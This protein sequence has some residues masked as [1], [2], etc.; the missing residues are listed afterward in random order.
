MQLS[1]A[2]GAEALGRAA[3][4]TCSQP[5]VAGSHPRP[6]PTHRI[7]GGAHRWRPYL[8]EEPDQE[9]EQSTSRPDRYEA[10]H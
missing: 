3:S 1:Q 4:G 5:P 10:G 7:A 9:L 8:R 2:T 6:P